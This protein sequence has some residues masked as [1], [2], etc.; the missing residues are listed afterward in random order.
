VAGFFDSAKMFVDGTP[1]DVPVE[2]A[3]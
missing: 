2:D 3:K 1:E